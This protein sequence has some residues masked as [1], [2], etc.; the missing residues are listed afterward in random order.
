[1]QKYKKTYINVKNQKEY[2][3]AIE[4]YFEKWFTWYTWEKWKST[5]PKEKFKEDFVV[6]VDD[7]GIMWTSPKD[8]CA[9]NLSKFKEIYDKS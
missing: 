7:D 5:I 2:E 3:R 9:L 6:L 8:R 1:M 4:F